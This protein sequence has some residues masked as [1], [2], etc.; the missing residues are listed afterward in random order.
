M[1][2]ESLAW[3]RSRSTFSVNGFMIFPI[4][5]I[6]A[7]WNDCTSPRKRSR[8]LIGSEGTLALIVEATLNFSR[9]LGVLWGVGWDSPTDAA[10][11]IQPNLLPGLGL[12]QNN[13]LTGNPIGNPTGLLNLGILGLDD[14]LQLD[15][16]L[17]AGEE[18]RQ[19]KV[20]SSP[21]VVTLDN[22]QAVI[23]QGVAIKFTEVTSD[24]INTSFVDAVLEL[25]VTPH[26]TANRSI[27]MK[28][29]VSKNS[30]NLS[31]ATGDIVGINKN[32]TKTEAILRDG[33]TM[34]LGGIYV[35]DNGH[36]S[37]KVPFLADI[38]GIGVF[39]RNKEV[40]DERRE[41][42]VFVT[43]R[44]VQGVQSDVQ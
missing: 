6:A 42:L 4:C 24:K 44:I 40:K 36:G 27:I 35:V 7:C 9:G 16:Q 37:T 30:P 20:I 26:I 43:P 15:M 21:R 14:K 39:F 12:Q 33:E 10:D 5:C 11:T 2:I 3:A 19:G 31:T 28:L 29:G 8:L 25:K 18:N 17:Q 23:K 1:S 13:F 41:L 34:V 38:P 32:E 22:K